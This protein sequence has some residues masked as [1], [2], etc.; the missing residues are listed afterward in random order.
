ME[1]KDIFAQQSAWLDTLRKG[2][3]DAAK[4][5]TAP[6]SIET[7]A[8]IIEGRIADLTRQKAAVVQQFDAAIALH[9][10][11][12]TAL[13]AGTP[14]NLTTNVLQPSKTPSKTSTKTSS[15][16]SSKTS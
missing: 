13:K 15:K 16:T 10:D 7:E 1:L 9:T 12:L 6:G 8:T 3:P 2:I 4:D 11:T 14:A 5:G